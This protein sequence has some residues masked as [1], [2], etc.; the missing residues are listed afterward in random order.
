MFCTTFRKFALLFAMAFSLVPLSLFAGTN[1]KVTGIVKDKET[2]DALPGVNIILDGT[3][4]GAATN[5]QGEFTIINVPAGVYTLSTS[6]IGYTKVTK[7]NVRI[8]P[9]FTTRVDFDL[10]PESLGGE[11]VVIVAERPLIQKDQT[12]TMTV[13]SSEEIKNL[14]VRGFQAAA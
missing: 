3:T 4:M 1:G 14:P 2:G 8:L 11:E 6:M 12:M 13:T 9:D 7:Q 10:S 5:A